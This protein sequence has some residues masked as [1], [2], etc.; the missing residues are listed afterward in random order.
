MQ[1]VLAMFPGQGSQYVGMGQKLLEAFPY[2]KSVFEEAEDACQ[3]PLRRLCQE[4]PESELKLTANTQPCLLAVSV[5]Y[6]RVLEKESGLRPTLFAGHSLG[7]YSALV[8]AGK[9]ALSRAAYLVHQRGLAMQEAVPAG[10][11]AMAA[12]MKIPSDQLEAL[13]EKHSQA[14]TGVRVEIANYNSDAQLVV[15]GHASAVKSLCDE[16]KQMQIR[17]VELP[18]SAPFHSSLMRPARERMQPLLEAT[19][20][21]SNDA[22]IIANVTGELASDYGTRYLIEQIDGPVRWIQTIETAQNLG[23]TRFVEVGPGKV[24]FGLVRRMVPRDGFEILATEDMTE[25]LSQIGGSLATN[26][27]TSLDI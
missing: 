16:L 11:G 4:G 17:S 6:W 15:A 19:T 27:S 22:G 1:N 8:A 21:K 18:V 10:V 13:C 7:E 3:L 24:L 20:L 26:R 5:A 14:A 9:L 12:V 23:V 2:A 25:A